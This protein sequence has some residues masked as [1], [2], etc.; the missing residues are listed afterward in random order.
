MMIQTGK[1]SQTEINLSN[2]APAVKRDVWAA[3]QA[4]APELAALLADE[5]LRALANRFD[6]T[7]SVERGQLPA[8][9]IDVLRRNA[10]NAA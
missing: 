5:T 10:R 1:A 9:A 2:L 6:G 8:G 7:L 3:I 4:E